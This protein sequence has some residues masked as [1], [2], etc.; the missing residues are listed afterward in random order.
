[1]RS[2]RRAEIPEERRLLELGSNYDCDTKARLE[3]LQASKGQVATEAMGP[4]KPS[5]PWGHAA[6]LAVS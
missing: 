1:M 3:L 4:M 6:R 5:K 2:H